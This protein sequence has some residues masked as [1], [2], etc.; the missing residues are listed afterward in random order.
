MHEGP[1]LQHR[2]G[3]RQFFNARADD[4][5]YHLVPLGEQFT[6]DSSSEEA[7]TPSEHY[8]ASRSALVSE[9]F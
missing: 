3:K 4:D 8:H 1:L 2:S 6:R 5:S 9:L 7:F